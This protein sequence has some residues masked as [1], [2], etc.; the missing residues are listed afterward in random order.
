MFYFLYPL[1]TNIL[2]VPRV[3]KC[4]VY[5]KYFFSIVYA[6]GC[7]P[8]VADTRAGK[9]YILVLNLLYLMG[10]ITQSYITYK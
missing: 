1:V 6:F 3:F 4:T 8:V 5:V 7:R 2:T 10:L 9:I